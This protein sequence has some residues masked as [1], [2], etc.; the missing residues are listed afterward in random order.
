MT[1]PNERRAQLLQWIAASR[2]LQVRLG[3]FVGVGAGAS[4]VALG[5]SPTAGKLGLALLAIFAIC[6]FWVTGS[7]ILDWRGQLELFDREARRRPEAAAPTAARAADG[8]LPP[9]HRA[10]GQRP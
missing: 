8:A 6:A 10:H 3:F 7:H 9:E 5:W 4:L 1:S 2:R